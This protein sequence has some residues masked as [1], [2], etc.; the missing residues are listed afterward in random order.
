LSFSASF[1]FEMI[2]GMAAVVLVVVAGEDLPR[3][4]KTVAGASISLAVEADVLRDTSPGG[5][6]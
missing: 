4:G 6:G 1:P 5:G 3:G 2:D